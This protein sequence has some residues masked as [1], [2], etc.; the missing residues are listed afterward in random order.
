MV[1]S[2]GVYR[3]QAAVML[4]GVLVPWVVS[5]IDMSQ[6]F[7]FFYV[8]TAAATFAV[9]GLAFFPG[10]FRLRLLDLTPVAW[11]AVV[12]RMNDPVVVIDALGPDRRVE[13][14]RRHAVRRAALWRD[15]GRRG[16][17]GVRHLASPRRPVGCGSMEYREASFE[18]DGPDPALDLAGSTRGSRGWATTPVPPAGSWSSATSPNGGKPR[19]NGSGC[20]GNRWPGPKPRRVIQA[21]DRFLATLSHELRTPLTPILAAATAMLDHPVSPAD[22]LPELLGMIRRNVVLEVRLIDDLLDLT[23]IR[24]GK[25]PPD[26]RGR[27]RARI[28]PSCHRDLPA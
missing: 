25:A 21:Q 14:G 5:I 2:A 4:F 22:D 13:P 26:A 15:S 18:I 10:L 20:S 9:T 3:A 23:R 19:K 27:R 24:G 11:A 8:D 12:E 17:A 28:D 1:R 16:G 7:G 6:V